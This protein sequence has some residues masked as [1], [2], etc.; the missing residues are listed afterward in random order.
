MRQ[1]YP[2]LVPFRTGRLR[3]SDRH[4]LYFEVSGNPDGKPVVFLHGGPGGGTV[5]MYR[6]F[7]DPTRWRIVLFDQRGCGQSTPHAELAENTTWD[8]V[9]DIERLRSHLQIPQW[10]VFGGSWG[11]T[12]ALAYAQTHPDSCTG[13]I[14]RG[15]FMLRPQEIRWFYQEG[16]SYIF[17]DAWEHY[18][19]PIPTEER[20]DLVTA[21]YR[22]LTSP[23]PATRQQ[24]AK[25]WSIWEASTSKLVTDPSLIDKFSGDA[26]A[27]A[28]ARIECHYFINGGFFDPPDQ[29]LKNINQIRHLPA[30]IVQGRYDV[31]CPMASAWA[32]HRA[33][34]EAELIVVPEA[35]HSATEPGITSALVDATDRFGERT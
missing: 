30:V 16:A 24:A 11:S 33:W 29:L 3:V 5:P 27:D 7:F 21:Y 23:D 35:G 4:E 20:D 31:V 10:A 18:L 1:L 22:R 28:F 32:L 19:A 15:I 2:P 34:P 26:F 25:A 6:Q 8:L 14:L 13:L 9:A 17:P 12:L